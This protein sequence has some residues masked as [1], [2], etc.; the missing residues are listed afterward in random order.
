MGQDAVDAIGPGDDAFGWALDTALGELANPGITC[1]AFHRGHRATCRGKAKPGLVDAVADLGPMAFGEPLLRK[2][3]HVEQQSANDVVGDLVR[4]MF[5]QRQDLALER[6]GETR[7]VGAGRR[8]HVGAVLAGSRGDGLAELLQALA[9]VGLD[10]DDGHAQQFRQPLVIDLDPLVNGDVDHVEGHDHGHSQLEDLGRQ[11][12]VAIEVGGIDDGDN[13]VGPAFLLLLA[14]DHIDGNHFVGAA[15][16]QAVGAGQIEQV[17]GLAGT[18]HLPFLGLDGDAGVVADVLV[19][20]GQGV[21]KGCLACIGIADQDGQ[22][23]AW[24]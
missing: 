13:D 6:L 18:G 20:A 21:E 17:E 22:A 16:R 5:A 7:S 1:T 12:Q 23:L 4:E 9:L 11:V 2:A 24:R 19:Q 15:R 14:Q 10:G 3:T 8:G